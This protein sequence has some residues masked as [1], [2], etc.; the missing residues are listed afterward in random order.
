MDDSYII[1]IDLG[2]AYSG[3]A[4]NITPKD[5][6][7]SPQVKRWGT[8]QGLDTPKAPNCI[9]FDER[10]RFMHFGYEAKDAYIKMLSSDAE[11]C[12]LF[13]TFKMSLYGKQPVKA[14]LTII[15]ANRKP[16]KALDVFAAA[17]Q[18][19]KEDALNT[20]NNSTRKMK[21]EA[22]DFTWVLTVPAIWDNA[23][24]QFMREAA[25]QAEIVNRDNEEKLVIAL[26]PE[27]A[28]I[29]CKRLPADG[30]LSENHNRTALQQTTG[31][32]YIVVDCGGGTIDITVH[33]VQ[34]NGKLKELHKASGNNLGGQTVD[35]KFKDFLREIFCDG[36]WDEFEA[37]HP[38]EVQ[39]LMYDFTFMKR[40]DQDGQFSCPYNLG[41]TASRHKMIEM[42]F[43][44]DKGASWNE[45]KIKISQ[46]K[47]RSFFEESLTGVTDSLRDI[48][49]NTTEIK[50][51]LLVGG[52]ALSQVLRRHIER[53][54]GSQYEVLCPNLP[55][56]AVLKGA[57]MFGSDKAVIV[58]RKSRFTYGFDCNVK[59]DKS[60]HAEEKK[61]MN[62]KG[63]W[64]SDVFYKM[65][66]IDEDVAYNVTKEYTFFPTT[67][68]QQIMTF[69][70]FRTER[71]D[72]KYIDEW[73]AE[74][75]G[76]FVVKMPDTTGG[77]NRE[78][79]ME[80]IFGD[81]E[82]TATATDLLSNSKESVTIDFIQNT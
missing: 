40:V 25:I 63:E 67:N 76:R 1:A 19:L 6:D 65:V 64:C 62:S 39:Q 23:A 34:M 8:E 52:Y 69:R 30:F 4:Y 49:E 47:M 70:F 31:T 18:F 54:F 42:F 75:I 17:L 26:E 55:Q 73:G 58:S 37:K 14:D 57:V 44:N 77:T 36:V 11:K 43:D 68:D 53:T 12:Y 16:M 3:Y 10:Q 15:A 32:Q 59:F 28:S 50:Y 81:T 48:L 9:L 45:G 24:K 80:V 29:W 7:L 51:I 33:E 5:K 46:K 41:Q 82:I 72:L 79:K 2:T 22:R 74:E 61:K 13:D 60:K 20:I 78:V 71:K 56:E 27:A 35:T 21:F 38:G 66:E